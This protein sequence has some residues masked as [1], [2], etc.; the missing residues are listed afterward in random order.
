M[1]LR[2]AYFVLI[3]EDSSVQEVPVDVSCVPN[4][5]TQTHDREVLELLGVFFTGELTS[6][7]FAERAVTELSPPQRRQLLSLIRVRVAET[8]KDISQFER[9]ALNCIESTLDEVDEYDKDWY[10]D[11]QGDA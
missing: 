9:A 8:G 5:E 4:L 1:K 2:A 3:F 10:C 11:G 6:D 7:E